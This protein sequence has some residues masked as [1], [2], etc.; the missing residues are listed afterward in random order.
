M[1]IEI[2]I[3]EATIAG[4]QSQVT[5]LTRQ[6]IIREIE[7]DRIIS[8]GLIAAMG[9]VGER[10]AAGTLYVPEMMMAA[11]AMKAG[12][13]I[14]RP[15]MVGGKVRPI[16][17]MVLGTVHGDMHDIGKNL[18][19]IMMEASGVEVI[20]LGINVPPENFVIA[21]EKHRPEFVGMSALLTVT[22][23]CMKTTI[24]AL[25]EAGLRSNLKILVGGA[26]VTQKFADEMGADFFAR[27]AGTAANLVKKECGWVNQ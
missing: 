16:A 2:Q 11:R 19:G 20:D 9:V 26:C 15:L 13:E 7:V 5:E 18:V 17:K 6:A 12:L 25:E 24:K 21:V 27:D 10:F 8:E 22:M 14:L 23:S 3:K 1:T 4:N